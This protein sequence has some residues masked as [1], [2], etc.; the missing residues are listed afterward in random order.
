M[1]LLLMR[2]IIAPKAICV[3]QL[4]SSLL[5]VYVCYIHMYTLLIGCR[6]Y[7]PGFKMGCIILNTI[8]P[9]F[10]YCKYQNNSLT[11]TP[12]RLVWKKSIVKL[13]NL[14]TGTLF[15]NEVQIISIEIGITNS[16]DKLTDNLTNPTR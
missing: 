14:K 4:L 7:F 2:A 1:I 9:S 12:R 11:T 10:I 15:L 16:P 3:S 13:M 5:V 8:I 6:Q